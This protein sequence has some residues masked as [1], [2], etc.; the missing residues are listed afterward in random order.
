MKEFLLNID[1][2]I[3]FI[4]VALGIILPSLAAVRLPIPITKDVKAIYDTI[5][6]VSAKNGTILISFDYGP[7]SMPEVQPMALAV[8]RHCFRK[9]VKVVGMSHWPTAVG[10][11]QEAFD[12]ASKEFVT[13]YGE[14]YTYLGYKPGGGSLVINMGR[15]FHDAFQKDLQGSDTTE[16]PVTKNIKG[17]ADFDYVICLASGNTP[18]GIW[19]PFGQERYKFKFGIGCTA[20]MAPDQYPYL[21]SGQMNGMMGGLAGAAEYETLIET[22][23][24]ATAGMGAQS[25]VHLIIIAFI[26][27]GNVMYFLYGRQKGGVQ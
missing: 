13:Q 12:T 23:D 7:G 1:R 11:A 2:R 4:F 8:L 5:E 6:E 25:F 21:Q 22:S 24:K 9:N 16:L 14:D 17:L 27:L 20:V 15:N 3:I 26:I 19:I 18:D 10:L